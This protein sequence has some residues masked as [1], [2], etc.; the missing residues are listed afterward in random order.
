MNKIALGKQIAAIQMMRFWILA[1][2]MRFYGI[3]VQRGKR[4]I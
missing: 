3:I 1:E 4:S 2:V